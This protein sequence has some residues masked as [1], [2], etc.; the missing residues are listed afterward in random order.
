M[1]KTYYFIRW[2]KIASHFPGR[3]DNEIKN[4]WNTHLKK[5]LSSKNNDP[6]GNESNKESSI[7]TSSSTSSISSI[8]SSQKHNS[9]E[10]LVEEESDPKRLCDENKLTSHEEI[11]NQDGGDDDHMEKQ[12]M[13]NEFSPQLAKDPKEQVISTTT[14]SDS[15]YGSNVSNGTT[16]TVQVNISRQGDHNEELLMDTLMFDFDE[17]CDVSDLLSEV[18]K[19]DNIE[20]NAMV[21]DQTLMPLEADNDF[22]GMLDSF[23]TN[24]FET[25]DN[26][27]DQ[28]HVLDNSKPC[29]NSIF[30]EEQN[31][32]IDENKK[33]LRYLESELGLEGTTTTNED[34]NQQV[35]LNQNHAFE[36]VIVPENNF[37]NEIEVT[38][39]SD[40]A[41]LNFS[42]SYQLWPY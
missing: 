22:W 16:S 10:V 32:E 34:Q 13:H 37:R 24:F 40:L 36:E 14:S 30:A 4:V 9:G 8:L 1:I 23:D 25:N 17:P 28:V 38:P 3:T 21:L 2:S 26:N 31:I 42:P 33:W 7:T 11:N 5:R 6:S 41:R 35:E 39:E 19:P 12:A 18:N 15:S 29:D 27:L 20:E